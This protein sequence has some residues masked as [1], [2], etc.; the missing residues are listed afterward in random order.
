M[1]VGPIIWL[2]VPEF[3]EPHV[4]PWATLSNWVVGSILSTIFPIVVDALP[5]RNAG[6]FFIGLLVLNVISII[7]IKMFAVE[8]K[9]KTYA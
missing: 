1:T 3:V 7:I 5:N 2:Y 9:D 8:T 6:P 4:L